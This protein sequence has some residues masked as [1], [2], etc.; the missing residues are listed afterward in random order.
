ML[1]EVNE[2]VGL[3]S[4]MEKE[5]DMKDL[6]NESNNND[7]DEEDS[8]TDGNSS[9]NNHNNQEQEEII[10]HNYNVVGLYENMA[11][12]LFHVSDQLEDFENVESSLNQ[13]FLSSHFF[14]QWKIEILQALNFFSSA[15][16][17]WSGNLNGHLLF[18]ETFHEKYDKLTSYQEFLMNPPNEVDKAEQNLKLSDDQELF[19][20]Y[21]EED[22]DDMVKNTFNLFV[23]LFLNANEILENEVKKQNEDI[24]DLS[25]DQLNVLHYFNKYSNLGYEEV[26]NFISN[27]SYP[28]NSN[29]RQQ[30]EDHQRTQNHEMKKFSLFLRKIG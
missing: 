10:L 14:Y 26:S 16:S 28:T 25:D 11:K 22:M 8:S 30:E 4:M 12:S 2:S 3:K 27:Y 21:Y 15:L 1:K 18:G 5:E 23:G 20:D 13:V 6:L 7:N 9:K 29:D 17:E 24:Q 19:L